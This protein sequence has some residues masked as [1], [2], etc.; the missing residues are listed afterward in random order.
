VKESVTKRSTQGTAGFGD[1]E[2]RDFAPGLLAIQETPP[3]RLPVAVLWLVVSLLGTLAV[4]AYFGRLDIIAS[5]EGRLVPETYVKIVQPSDGGIVTEILVREGEAVRAGQVVLRMDPKIVQADVAAIA[6]ELVSKK[7]Q[8][9][10]ANAELAGTGISRVA[11]DQAE[12]FAQVQAQYRARRQAY[13]DALDYER[14]N[15]KRG[16]QE[17]AAAEQLLHKLEQT[18]PIYERTADSYRRLARENFLSAMAADEK[19]R[20][21]IEKEQ[22]LKSQAAVVEGL[23]AAIGS[24][25][26]KIAQIRSGYES[27]LQ[28]ERLDLA[29][30][31]H[32]LEQEQAKVLHKS[33]LLQLRAPQSGI[34]K[35]LATHTVGSVVQ[36][37]TVLMTLVPQGEPLQAEIYVRN[38]DVGFLHVGQA[39]KVKVVSYPF[40]K[41]GLLEGTVTHIS[42]DAAELGAADAAANVGRGMA[43]GALKYKALV[44][45][46][47]QTL[48]FEGTDLTLNPGM[49]VAAEIHQG[50]RTVLEYLLSPLQKAAREAARER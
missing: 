39:A 25:G 32:K 9:R 40:Q 24:S 50:Q 4:W 11:K 19:L 22:E 37:G 46:S 26:K 20:E 8:L 42:A 33:S 7:L 49:Q 23:R 36:P 17:L 28:N 48:Q 15:L 43:G 44:K 29:A 3:R 10:R 21:K 6:N 47:R 35:D 1:P 27:Q 34:V 13:Q 18:V 30:Q 38:E 31:I 14:E 2:T 45:L 12:L 41:Y 16:R 5:A